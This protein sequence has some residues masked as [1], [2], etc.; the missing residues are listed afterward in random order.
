MIPVN[1]EALK[2]D[3]ISSL[4]VQYPELG[5]EGRRIL[6]D[7]LVG[8][9]VEK[10]GTILTEGEVANSIMFVGRGMVRQFYYK[11]KKDVTEH[12][13]YEGSVLACLESLFT[14]QPSKI[15]V[16]ALELTVIFELKWDD[17]Q[18]LVEISP[19]MNRF[20]R[21]LLENALILSQ[22]KA[23][24]WRFET[25]KSRY[26]RMLKEYPEVI[27][28]APMLQIASYLLMTPETLSRIRSEI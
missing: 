20:Y 19:E 7:A 26:Q 8:R 1:I 3:M 27:K 23:D 13:S 17:I 16:E 24:A 12:F 10:G 21:K 6:S 5:T 4:A 14:R 22:Q 9:R 18:R 2:R 11:N 28:R 15:I 25:A